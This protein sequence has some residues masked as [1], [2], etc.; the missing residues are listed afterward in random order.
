[1]YNL[2]NVLNIISLCGGSPNH[3]QYPCV[4]V[5]SLRHSENSV[6]NLPAEKVDK[7]NLMLVDHSKSFSKYFH[8]SKTGIKLSPG[9]FAIYNC[10]SW[11]II[12]ILRMH[13]ASSPSMLHTYRPWSG[14]Y[15]DI[16]LLRSW[17]SDV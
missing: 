16:G 6:T 2:W 11:H 5:S 7:N 13:Q 8:L 3:I 10:F 4:S 15:C 17:P 1:M 9:S 12:D 14:L